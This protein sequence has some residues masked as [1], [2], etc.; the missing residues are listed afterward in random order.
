MNGS[1]GF[2]LR[3]FSLYVEELLLLLF[4]FRFDVFAPSRFGRLAR[5]KGVVDASSDASSGA[6]LSAM[7]RFA[8]ISS[9]VDG[10][11]WVAT[12]DRGDSFSC[13][14]MD[15]PCR[16]R[17]LSSCWNRDAVGGCATSGRSGIGPKLCTCAR[18]RTN[19]R[20]DA[21]LQRQLMLWEDG[22]TFCVMHAR[23]LPGRVGLVTWVRKSSRRWSLCVGRQK[24]I[25]LNCQ[26]EEATVTLTFAV[27]RVKRTYR[28][29]KKE[30]KKRR[31]KRIDYMKTIE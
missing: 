29:S 30:K 12:L 22:F 28:K 20:N 14:R 27:D 17:T 16:R 15:V 10:V 9:A 3:L 7:C 21:E 23:K 4:G 1:V 11:D 2:S 19:I 5:G 18:L 8:G 31:K 25:H 26:A 24:N 6:A 13:W